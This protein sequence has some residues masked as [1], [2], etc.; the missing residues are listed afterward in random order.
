MDWNDKIIV[1]VAQTTGDPYQFIRKI[2]EL[3]DPAIDKKGDLFSYVGMV[4]YRFSYFNLALN[5]WNYALKEYVKNLDKRGEAECYGNIA[6]VH[7]SFGDLRMA[8]EHSK[9][10]LKIAQEIGNR[11]IELRCYGNLGNSYLDL[12]NSRLALDYHLKSLQLTRKEGDRAAELRSHGNIGNVHHYMGNF[13]E[14]LSCYGKSLEI[15]IDTATDPRKRAVTQIW[16]WCAIA[17][18]SLK[19]P[20]PIFKDHSKSPRIF[21]IG[22][23][24]LRVTQI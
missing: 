15:A 1:N 18:D 11:H 2:E 24:R 9:R 13:R 17:Q 16:A 8:I 3:F 5:S 20:S 21:K 6:L 14:A 7:D 10:S 4:L 12:G 22:L 19:R 23:W